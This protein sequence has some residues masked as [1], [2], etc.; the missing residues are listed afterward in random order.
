MD[1]TNI[2]DKWKLLIEDVKVD[3]VAGVKKLAMDN[4]AI[5]VPIVG[6]IVGIMILKIARRG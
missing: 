5:V 4:L 6:L 1:L 3:P 2:W